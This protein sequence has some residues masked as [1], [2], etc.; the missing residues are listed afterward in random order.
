MSAFSIMALWLWANLRFFPSG[1]D[2]S[3]LRPLRPLTSKKENLEFVLF[4]FFSIKR[5]TRWVNGPDWRLSRLWC[6]WCWF[7]HNGQNDQTERTPYRLE[8]FVATGI[9]LHCSVETAVAEGILLTE[10]QFEE[11]QNVHQGI[12]ERGSSDDDES[13]DKLEEQ[14]CQ[15]TM[16]ARTRCSSFEF[17]HDTTTFF[18]F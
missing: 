4:C 1:R 14:I 15:C 3:A 6:L 12:S 5:V 9:E 8:T 16:S 11:L 13:E 7:S 2:Q 10:D 17:L 18:D